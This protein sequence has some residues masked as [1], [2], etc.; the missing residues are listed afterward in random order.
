MINGRRKAREA[1]LQALYQCDALGDW[2][3]DAVELYFLVFQT[4]EH[5]SE[6]HSE[7]RLFTDR[8]IQGVISNLDIIDAYIANASEHWSISRMPRVDRNILRFAIFEIAFCDDIPINVSINEAIE[9]AKRF[10]AD[11]APMFING[12]LDKVAQNLESKLPNKITTANNN[13]KKVAN[14]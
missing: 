11:D 5:K 7:S 8:L 14:Y 3:A 9:V 1:A 10:S 13:K 6:E 4:E 12:V 2:S